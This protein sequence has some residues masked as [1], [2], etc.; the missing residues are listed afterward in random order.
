MTIGP[1][2]LALMA[3][4]V[5]K[6]ADPKPVWFREV[7]TWAY[8]AV[9]AIATTAVIGVGLW[10]R[11]KKVRKVMY[12]PESKIVGSE[13]VA[14]HPASC[15]VFICVEDGSQLVTIGSGL[16]MQVANT[17]FLV[18]ASHCIQPGKKH[19]MVR[20]EKQ[21]QLSEDVVM[22][23][24]DVITDIIAIPLPASAFSAVGVRVAKTS[25]MP[26]SVHVQITGCGQK[27][28]VGK[29]S[30]TA[31]F[32]RV[33]YDATTQAG[34]SGAPYMQG[35][36]V[37]AI[38]TNGGRANEGWEI[39]YIECLLWNE[40]ILPE[41]TYGDS[42]SAVRRA[43][44]QEHDITYFGDD[45][46]VR[47][48]VTGKYHRTKQEIYDELQ[49]ARST[50]VKQ[51]DDWAAQV[52]VEDLEEQYASYQPESLNSARMLPPPPSLKDGLKSHQREPLL[53]TTLPSSVTNAL[54]RP[55]SSSRKRS[56]IQKLRQEIAMLKT[57]RAQQSQVPEGTHN[58]R[59]APRRNGS[60]SQGK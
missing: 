10:S 3:K 16:R 21:Y 4:K 6:Q 13:E 9:G 49:R 27:G 46:V 28:T 31:T 53:E 1:Q 26:K 47:S 57:S 40:D 33:V 20:G 48:R 19:W 23:Y 41:A 39:K 7:P 52:E 34:Y 5:V 36:V 25:P 45:L 12:V 56:L 2:L 44:E 18:T 51:P 58:P 30:P 55:S 35:G 24:R 42:E 14:S 8:G 37:V 11:K 15:Q 60:P 54:K 32:G 22:Q 17:D 50:L 43:I 38:H 59:P 29:L